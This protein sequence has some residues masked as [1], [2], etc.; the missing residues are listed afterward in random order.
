MALLTF[1]GW[2]L[3]ACGGWPGH[4][5]RVSSTSPL[6][7]SRENQQGLQAQT[8]VLWLRTRVS[9]C[10]ITQGN[11]ATVFVSAGS[12]LSCAIC[13]PF[14]QASITVTGHLTASQ[15]RFSEKSC[16]LRSRTPVLSSRKG[17]SVFQEASGLPLG[18]RVLPMEGYKNKERREGQDRRKP[19]AQGKKDFKKSSF[20]FS[21]PLG[22]QLVIVK[23]PNCI[24]Y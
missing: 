7:L 23:I 5:G 18:L 15:P 11:I 24:C 9:H 4:S 14:S 22:H 2:I 3:L 19:E 8:Q 6:P 17:G 20:A 13:Y 12:P 16:P 1:W 10:I 21:C